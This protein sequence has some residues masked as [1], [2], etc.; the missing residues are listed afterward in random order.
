MCWKVNFQN[1]HS[2]K[3]FHQVS[4]NSPISLFI[5]CGDH[6][7]I[8]E[9]GILKSPTITML[10]LIYYNIFKDFNTLSDSQYTQYTYKYVTLK[11]IVLVLKSSVPM[12]EACILRLVL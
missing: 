6:L 12:F 5:F 1:S 3:T 2:I 7:S 4:L 9:N 8:G 11:L 10:G